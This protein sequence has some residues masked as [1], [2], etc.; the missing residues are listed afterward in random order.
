MRYNSDMED[1]PTIAETM[2]QFKAMADNLKPKPKA[3]N[4]LAGRRD[5]DMPPK[6]V[7]SCRPRRIVKW[8]TNAPEWVVACYVGDKWTLHRYVIVLGGSLWT[9]DEAR[10]HWRAG[11]N[12]R[13]VRCLFF[14]DGQNGTQLMQASH[15]LLGRHLGIKTH[16]EN[17]PE[18]MRQFV[19]D[20]YSQ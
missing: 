6:M 10:Q 14:L 18:P 8:L 11:M 17:I 19:L 16:W 4:V 12:P 20:H 9:A 5:R 15:S 13:L 2:A 1:H 3:R 7:E